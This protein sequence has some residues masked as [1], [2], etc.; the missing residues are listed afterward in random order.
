MKLGVQGPG[1]GSAA[2]ADL[3]PSGV[4]TSSGLTPIPSDLPSLPISGV[5][6]SSLESAPPFSP[7]SPAQAHKGKQI[8]AR[9]KSMRGCRWGGG[10]AARAWWGGCGGSRHVPP[11]LGPLSLL[12]SAPPLPRVSMAPEKKGVAPTT[13]RPARPGDR[14]DLREAVPKTVFASLIFKV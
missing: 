2:P 9:T 3:L 10:V 1:P 5:S 4:D 14:N 7:F 12:E 11:S 13:K 8:G 6:L